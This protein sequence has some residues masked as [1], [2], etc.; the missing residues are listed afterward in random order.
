MKERPIIMTAESVRAIL[1]GRKSQTRRL[2]KDQR[3]EGDWLYVDR[4]ARTYAYRADLVGRGG[5]AMRSLCP[6]GAPGDRLYVKEAWA[7]GLDTDGDIVPDA[8]HVIY[9]ERNP[10]HEAW[11]VSS[12]GLHESWEVVGQTGWRSPM[13]MPRWASRLTL[14]VTGVRVERL[15]AITEAD[16]IAEGV[17]L[18][19]R[20]ATHY[21][22]TH[23]DAY[24]ALWD[25]I[26]GK[27]APWA[28]NPWVWVVE[29]RQVQP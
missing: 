28:S 22:D 7:A 17:T 24:A 16:A 12:P 10:T 6:Y 26:N 18:P 29:F 19:E 2:I 3:S 27:R 8:R 4:G 21:D 5:D 11:Y 9:R 13:F 1:A 15:Q 23:R 20:M 14:A 25:R